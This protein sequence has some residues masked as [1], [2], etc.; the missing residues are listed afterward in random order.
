MN[1][2]FAILYCT[3]ATLVWAIVGLTMRV[4]Y[5]LKN[6]KSKVVNGSFVLLCGFLWPMVLAMLFI[7]VMM[8]AAFIP[9][10]YTPLFLIW[11]L[12]FVNESN[13]V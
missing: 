6:G 10:K 3:I 12:M 1:F 9:F 13:K 5:N 11:K 7:T 8:S 4:D 2:I